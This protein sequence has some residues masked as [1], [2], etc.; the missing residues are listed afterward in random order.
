MSPKSISKKAGK[1][2]SSQGAARHDN[3]APAISGVVTPMHV[4]ATPATAI[5]ALLTSTL[6]PELRRASNAAGK[7][8]SLKKWC[9]DRTPIHFSPEEL[10]PSDQLDKG[11]VVELTGQQKTISAD[12]HQTAWSEV[13]YK[14]ES[15]W[16]RGWVNDAYLDD[17]HEDFPDS[18]VVILHQTKELWDAQQYMVL[19]DGKTRYNMCGELC[20]AFI[21]NAGIDP[22]LAKWQA[23]DPK[24]YN[25]I[26]A[27]GQD[28]LTEDTDLKNMLAAVLK[29]YGYG[30]DNDQIIPFRERLTFP[31]DQPGM[32]ADLRK[33]LATHYLIVLVTISKAGGGALIRKD[34]P[35]QTK[36]WVMLDKIIRNGN[37]VQIYNPF[38]NKREEYS[39]TE[40]YDS[41]Q[42][43]W[44]GLW[45]KRKEAQ[46][47]VPK[48]TLPA[49][50]VEIA[51]ANIKYSAK[52]YLDVDGV[53]QVN[54]CGEFCVS[55]IVNESINQVLE[56]WK[57]IQPTIYADI[58]GNSK[59]TGLEKLEPILRSYG[60]NRPG[61]IL[62]F[63]AG[64]IDPVLKKS[65]ST[66]GRLAK[67]LETHW[68]IAGVGIDDN[69]GQLE[70]SVQT[71]HWVVV[72]KIIPVGRDDRGNGGWV[73]LYNPFQNRWE[74]YSYREFIYSVGI[75]GTWPTNYWIVW[76]G[77]WVKRNIFSNLSRL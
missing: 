61:D 73:Q 31:V 33:M 48:E 52:Q 56:H 34:S 51:N 17:Y 2:G 68:L 38:S 49:F 40:F 65:V 74:E 5:P 26:L 23:N 54:L 71:R 1:K 28:N 58:I 11:F 22:V 60:Y 12:D 18:G 46:L 75:E 7:V 39:F 64:L 69:T 41:C 21:V 14:A 66:P 9:V 50:E 27:N 20:V 32:L 57:T 62:D 8:Q 16:V 55:F 59:K 15:A 35:V 77:L 76:G 36:H 25:N 42:S 30:S 4:A 10:Q 43:S 6:Q 63:S 72:D 67:R 45:V 13:A 37:R 47:A 24:S 29:E 3:Q 44:K 53:K 70:P 19:G